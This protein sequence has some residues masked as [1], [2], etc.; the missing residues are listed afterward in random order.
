MLKPRVYLDTTV[1]SALLDG[2]SPERQELTR[3]FWNASAE[4]YVLFI[5]ELTQREVVRT[6]KVEHRDALLS[7]IEPLTMLPTPS[8][9]EELA[10]H[11]V[12]EGV[13]PQKYFEDALHLAIATLNA[14]TIV[15][16]WNFRHMVKVVTRN[17]VNAVNANMGYT[18]LDI[19]TPAQL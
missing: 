11:Y 10:E 18:S 17:R 9:A 8:E 6:P 5:S 2:R 14:V 3:A 16:S 13:M 1:P 4:R 19:V 12:R 15:A 7:L